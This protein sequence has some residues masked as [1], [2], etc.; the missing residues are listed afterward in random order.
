MVNGMPCPRG[1]V[2]G[3]CGGSLCG[4]GGFFPLWGIEKAEAVHGMV[5]AGDRDTLRLWPGPQETLPQ[6]G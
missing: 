5:L 6:L 3:G 1:A 4:E 2:P